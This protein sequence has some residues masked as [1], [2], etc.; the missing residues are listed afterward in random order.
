MPAL[1]GGFSTD[2]FGLGDR[3]EVRE[4]GD[5]EASAVRWGMALVVALGRHHATPRYVSTR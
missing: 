2:R 5:D 3:I 1:G 4:D